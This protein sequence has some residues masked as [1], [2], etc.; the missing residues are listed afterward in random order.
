M[1]TQTRQVVY[2]NV[3]AEEVRDGKEL[4]EM[5]SEAEGHN[6]I[7]NGYFD[8]AYDSVKNYRLLEE[9]GI[10]P[11]IRPRRSSCLTR[12]RIGIPYSKGLFLN[13]LIVRNQRI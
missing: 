7:N 11:V 6:R 12:V 3:T 1:N 4:P 5:V 13:M 10:I 9:K 2:C 8:A